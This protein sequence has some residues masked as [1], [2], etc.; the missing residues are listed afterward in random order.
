MARPRKVE[1]VTAS[2]KAALLLKN[3][4]NLEQR[5]EKFAETV[6]RNLQKSLIDT[7]ITKKENL[8][9][10]IDSKLDFSLNVDFNK[11]MHGITRENAEQRFDE[12][13]DLRYRLE[14]VSQELYIKQGIFN[15]YFADTVI[16]KE[17]SSE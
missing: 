3:L 14:L 17:E 4:P 15:D 13:I 10:T 7:L 16:A 2:N 5:A 6:K 11:G 1:L 9:D 8:E 12:V